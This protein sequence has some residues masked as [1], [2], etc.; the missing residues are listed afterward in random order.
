MTRGQVASRLGRSISTV[1]RLEGSE[2]H[3]TMGPRGVR[4]F[5]EDE[6]AAVASRVRSTGSV[7]S[8]AA[9]SESRTQEDHD[10]TEGFELEVQDLEQQLRKARRELEELR[11]GLD[12]VEQLQTADIDEIQELC[13][14][15]MHGPSDRELEEVAR[16]LDR[17]IGKLR[18][19]PRDVQLQT[20]LGIPAW[21]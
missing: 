16:R 17:A 7:S 9:Q 15:L 13:I 5:D 1:R 4:L 19:R 8:N 18:G 20:V 2:L 10:D 21:P 3:P 11:K 14:R 6:V 12:Y